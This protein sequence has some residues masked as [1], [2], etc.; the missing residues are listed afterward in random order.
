MDV[1]QLFLCSV[2]FITTTLH[3]TDGI[4]EG[5]EDWKL[6]GRDEVCCLKCNPGNRLVEPCGQNIFKL[7]TPCEPNTYTD[8]PLPWSCKPCTRCIEP[9]VQ[10]KPCSADADTV[11]GCKSGLRCGNQRCEYCV[12]ECRKGQ[13]PTDNRTCRDCPEGTF[14]DEIHS[15]CKPWT[16]SCPKGE[17]I[18]ASGNKFHDI[19]CSSIPVITPSASPDKALYLVIGCLGGSSALVIIFILW[20]WVIHKRTKNISKDPEPDTPTHGELTF[21]IVEHEEACSF[22]Q[23]EQE[24][25]GSSESINTQDSEQKLIP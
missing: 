7:C 12:Q 6:S 8:V 14:N 15:T 11:C 22:H 3:T 1:L 17:Y 13:E 5:C 16:E 21:M 2:L 23:P 10:L 4:T 25:G 9:Q 20:L 18:I 19:R 24:Q